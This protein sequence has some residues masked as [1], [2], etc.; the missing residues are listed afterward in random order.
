M[1][2]P[3]PIEERI[4]LGLREAAPDDVPHRVLELA[5]ERTRTMPQDRFVG[6]G[7]VRSITRRSPV[8][9][10]LLVAAV[11]AIAAAVAVVGAQLLQPDQPDL[12]TRVLDAGV[13]RV[14]VRSEP[15]QAVVPSAGLTGFDVDVARELSSRLGVDLDLVTV[16]ADEAGNGSGDAPWD[17]SI[18]SLPVA[19]FDPTAIAAGPA[20]YAWPRYVL[21]SASSP[22]GSLDELAGQIVCAVADDAGADWAM[23]SLGAGTV[24]LRPTDDACL[25]ELDAGRVSGVVTATLGPADLVVRA[26]YRSIGGPPV[27][28]RMIAAHVDDRPASM[29][30]ELARLVR[31]MAADGTLAD[32]SSRRFG[33]VDLSTSIVQGGG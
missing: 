33:G 17:I 28:Q 29:L 21:V 4:S 24:V 12:R 31:D 18:A 13:L 22:L 14:A 23:T 9:A 8:R 30:D 32:L 7:R 6:R 25:G 2:H 26:Q 5:F 11:L 1:I 20:Y 19:A 27:E 10:A 16:T 15:P 3:R